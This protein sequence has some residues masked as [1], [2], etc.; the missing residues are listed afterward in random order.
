MK[1]DEAKLDNAQG[2]SNDLRHLA[3][4]ITDQKNRLKNLQ[5]DFAS[6]NYAT[7]LDEKS[8]ETRS[9]E[10]KKDALHGEFKG[11][12]LQADSRARLGLKRAEVKSK[13]Q[14]VKNTC[15]RIQIGPDNLMILVPLAC[16]S[17]MP[18][19]APSSALILN[20]RQ[21]SVTSNRRSRPLKFLAY[22]H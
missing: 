22:F 16:N 14:D 7:K 20:L 9:L 18:S 3:T 5:D 15:V 19:S 21:W 1:E 17:T 8:K 13:M 11:L 6:A 12:G 10:D 4:D 2:L